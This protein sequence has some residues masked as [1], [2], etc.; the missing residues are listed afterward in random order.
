MNDN[1][2]FRVASAAHARGFAVTPLRDKS[3]FLHAW[4][5]H[6]LTT[7]TDIRAAAKDCPRCDV[8]DVHG[9]DEAGDCTVQTAYLLSAH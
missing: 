5:R 6:P 7:E 3:P 1:Y 9:M 4:N 8:R 2:F